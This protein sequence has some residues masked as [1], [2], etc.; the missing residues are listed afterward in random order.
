MSKV[1]LRMEKAEP[2]MCYTLSGD[3]R[4]YFHDGKKKRMGKE[5]ECCGDDIVY[6]QDT[7]ILQK[8][9]LYDEFLRVLIKCSKALERYECPD[10]GTWC[11][12]FEECEIRE[13]KCVIELAKKIEEAT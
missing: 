9:A 3:K 12:H 10:C 1:F 2:G 4:C 13:S 11:E 7:T 8:L 5:C 6:I